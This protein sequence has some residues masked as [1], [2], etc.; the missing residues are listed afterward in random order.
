MTTTKTKIASS[1]NNA[2]RRTWS[3]TPPPVSKLSPNDNS[4]NY[5]ST[6]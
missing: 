2:T 1:G 6:T 4:N 3:N 5:A